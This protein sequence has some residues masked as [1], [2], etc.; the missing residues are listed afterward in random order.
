MKTDDFEIQ[1]RQEI[2]RGF[3]RI[4]A[5]TLRFKKFDGT[6]SAWMRRELIERPSA[7]AVL[8]YDPVHAQLIFIEQFRLGAKSRVIEIVAGI[9]EPGETPEDVA[10][11]EAVEE[12]GLVIMDL[13]PIQSYWT[14]AGGAEERLH[15]FCGRVDASSAG[16][17]YGLAEEDEDIKV[18][19]F[20]VE[21]ATQHLK[22]QRL[23]TGPAIIAMQ[24]F[25]LNKDEVDTVWPV[26]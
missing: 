23:Q 10:R 8:L 15:L 7:V 9:V 22:Q 2:Y 11:R 26:M 16:G 12:A 5:Y 1:S 21:E 3:I 18:H 14:S 25:L 13:L 6:W 19:V 4:A 17:I 24:W 20:S